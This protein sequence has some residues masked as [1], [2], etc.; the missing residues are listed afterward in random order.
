MQPAYRVGR[1]ASATQP[2]RR[3]QVI[4][5]MVMLVLMVIMIV[6]LVMMVMIMLLIAN[7]MR[8]QMINDHAHPS[9]ISFFRVHTIFWVLKRLSHD[10]CDI[11]HLVKYARKSQKL[12]HYR[13]RLQLGLD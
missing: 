8:E 9:V 3:E 2:R 10:I 1:E 6:M 7:M 4:F 13:Y 5:Q 11:S 12:R